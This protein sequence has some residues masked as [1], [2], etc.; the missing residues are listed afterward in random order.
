MMLGFCQNFKAVEV[1]VEVVYNWEDRKPEYR[2]TDGTRSIDTFP[3]KLFPGKV[4][5]LK[6][7][8]NILIE[9]KKSIEDTL[10]HLETL[11][12]DAI[13]EKMG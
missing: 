4:R 12:Y 5:A 8:R 10:V 11:M 7:Q 1:E 13:L 3:S 2:V 9:T 6:E